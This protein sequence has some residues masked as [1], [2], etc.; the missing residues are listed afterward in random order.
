VIP[1]TKETIDHIFE[2]RRAFSFAER[3]SGST[4]RNRLLTD[5]KGRFYTVAKV[6]GQWEWYTLSRPAP[7]YGLLYGARWGWKKG[8]YPAWVPMPNALQAG[9]PNEL[10]E[11]LPAPVH[12]QEIL[13]AFYRLAFPNWDDIVKIEGWPRVSEKTWL[14]ICNLFRDFDRRMHPEVLPGGAWS[15]GSGFSSAT[16]D[17]DRDSLPDWKIDLSPCRVAYKTTP[18][19]FEINESRYGDNDEYSSFY[20]SIHWDVRLPEPW[21][22]QFMSESL[23]PRHEKPRPHTLAEAQADCQERAGCPLTWESVAPEKPEFVAAVWRSH[24]VRPEVARAA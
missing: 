19:W 1:L 5:G 9:L 10:F 2:P 7:D 17:R 6:N 21:A 18:F 20:P 16:H 14:Y 12:Q 3:A 24:T 4:M 13:L 8:T 15:L 23:D 22:K 11:C